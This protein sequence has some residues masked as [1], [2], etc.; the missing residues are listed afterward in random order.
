MFDSLDQILY[1]EFLPLESRF[2][3]HV[4]VLWFRFTVL[5]H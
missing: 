4:L 5:N 3:N 1:V 2:K